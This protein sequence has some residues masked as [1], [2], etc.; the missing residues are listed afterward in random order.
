MPVA[1]GDAGIDLLL[2]QRQLKRGR[3]KG[4][5]EEEEREGEREEEGGEGPEREDVKNMRKKISKKE[6]GKMRIERY[7]L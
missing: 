3:G 1:H 7:N 5:R 6:K 2:L 4:G